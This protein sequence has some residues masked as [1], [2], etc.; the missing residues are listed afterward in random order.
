[1]SAGVPSGYSTKAAAQARRL[2]S[3]RGPQDMLSL[4]PWPQSFLKT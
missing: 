4:P 1:M 2:F 3:M